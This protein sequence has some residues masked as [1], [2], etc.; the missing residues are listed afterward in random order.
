MKCNCGG[1]ILKVSEVD[2]YCKACGA[3]ADASAIEDSATIASG[4]PAE[5]SIELEQS[6]EVSEQIKNIAKE[7]LNKALD[8]SKEVT[9]NVAD[10]SKKVAGTSKRVAKKGADALK[11]EKSKKIIK[12]TVIVSLVVAV[13]I[14]V[15]LIAAYALALIGPPRHTVEFLL[16]DGTNDR[17]TS[18]I[19]FRGEGAVNRLDDPSREG[20]A[21][22]FWAT[23]PTAGRR[24]DLPTSFDESITLYARWIAE[25]SVTIRLNDGTDE[26]LSE[27]I[28]HDG[29]TIDMPTE[30]EKYGHAFVRWTTDQAGN[31]PFAFTASVT[32]PLSLY[33]QWIAER[34]VT[35]ML[36]DGT[37]SMYDESVVKD[38]ETIRQPPIP[39]RQGYAFTNW[40]ADNAGNIIFDFSIPVT[41]DVIIYAQW[42]PLRTVSINRNYAGAATVL[43]QNLTDGS[44]V[45]QVYVPNRSGF[46][47][48]HW[49][50]DATGHNVVSLDTVINT[51]ITLYA[52]WQRTPV[53]FVEAVPPHEAAASQAWA[54]TG[55]FVGG[56]IVMAGNT[57]LN[58]MRY[59]ILSNGR[60]YSFS[61]QNLNGNFENLSGIIG[62]IDGSAMSDAIITF[63]GDGERITYFIIR[64]TDL[65]RQISVD[66][67]DVH[68]LRIEVRSYRALGG[69]Q[70]GTIGSFALANAW[71]S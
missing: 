47:F 23:N 54:G 63:H 32:S 9:K 2:A 21:F 41:N 30:P 31:Q 57:Y 8:A 4:I 17:H 68:L 64:A 60:S 43:P 50:S 48:I 55:A 10:V 13:V 61:L 7:E 25:H 12:R 45:S 27:F 52:Q 26:I 59:S 44:T 35:L 38:G 11:T 69:W 3:H 22:L 29:Y 5:Q 67:T 53:V 20:Y 46:D 70:S 37:G 14:G 18:N 51:N 36:N 15:A 34:R 40:T 16:N 66:V 24:V 58:S 62:R 49:T 71:I 56:S 6:P 19:T 42:I 39:L 28:T 1:D 65:P 33:A